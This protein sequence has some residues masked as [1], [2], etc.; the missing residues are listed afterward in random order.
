MK[1][2]AFIS[3]LMSGFLTWGILLPASSQVTSDRTTNTTVK[4]NGNNFNILNGI[5][6]RN[7]LFHSFKDFSIP[8]GSSAVFNNYTDVVN[9][10]NWVTGG[11]ISNIDGLIKAQGNANLFLINPAGIVFGENA[12][13][14][15]GGSFFG[16]TAESILFKDGFEFKAVNS[17]EK[18]LLT[19]SL[20][21]GL[22]MGTNPGNI[23]VNGRG[24]NLVAQDATFAPYINLGSANYLQ[25][26]RGKTLALIGGDIQLD[27][28]ILTA[29]SGI[30]E[31]ASLREGTFNNGSAGNININSENIQVAGKSMGIF[32]TTTITS[33][34]FGKGDAA[35]LGINTQT[36]SIRD[37]ASVNTTSHDSGNAGSVTVNAAKWSE[38]K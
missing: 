31:L 21:V 18:P 7:N 24:H 23:S 35:R 28:G 8:Q 11:S 6:K 4:P 2:I 19:V 5:Q 37:G 22:Q 25:V 27:D 29:E 10:I 9:I 3:G 34:S 20:P 36:L 16:S 30:V 38:R 13:L 32:R 33:T 15:I 1:G 17:E 12:S 26:K 14:D